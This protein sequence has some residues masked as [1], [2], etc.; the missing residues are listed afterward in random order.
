M[1]FSV[2]KMK[3]EIL[4]CLSIDGSKR[5]ELPAYSVGIYDDYAIYVRPEPYV[6]HYLKNQ[7]FLMSHPELVLVNMHGHHVIA[8]SI[9]KEKIPENMYININLVP[10]RYIDGFY[11]KDLE[12]DIK[13]SRS[14]DGQLSPFVVDF[15]EYKE[16]I[17]S[18][19]LCEIVTRE[20]TRLV[21][22]IINKKFPFAQHDLQML[23]SD[24]WPAPQV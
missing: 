4:C 23:I 21:E 3:K 12:L 18:P 15:D 13:V 22:D 5:Y 6:V 17:E 1:T 11:W 16:K 19:E 10:K 2:P 7:T 24:F 20:A 14:F 9:N 8:V